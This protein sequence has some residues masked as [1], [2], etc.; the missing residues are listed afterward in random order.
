MVLMS[1]FSEYLRSDSLQFGFKCNSSCSHTLFTV[2]TVTDHYV[3]DGCT[4]NICS[5]DIS[6][7][8]DTIDQYALLQ[9]LLDRHVPGNFIGLL[10]DWF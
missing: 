2:K 3:K 9:F 4:T 7:A 10:L 8:F 1:L 5:L 6:K